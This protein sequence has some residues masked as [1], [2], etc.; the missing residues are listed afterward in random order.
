MTRLF[1]SIK[2]ITGDRKT[3][4]AHSGQLCSCTL[5]SAAITTTVANRMQIKNQL[6]SL[7]PSADND[8]T[9][10]PAKEVLNPDIRDHPPLRRCLTRAKVNTEP[11]K[12]TNVGCLRPTRPRHL[13]Y[14]SRLIILH[15][16]LW[17]SESSVLGLC[18]RVI[19]N[20]P[21]FC[22]RPRTGKT[23]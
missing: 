11:R 3:H 15:I 12:S 7:Y 23:E 8:T 10:V 17:Q 21:G 1:I 5:P 9:C 20:K 6:R 19:V 22:R 2:G 18:L 16:K 14:H 4:R 13:F